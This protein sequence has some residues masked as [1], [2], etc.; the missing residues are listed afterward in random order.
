MA[1]PTYDAPSENPQDQPPVQPDSTEI[2]DADERLLNAINSLE[3]VA[4]G[5]AGNSQ[6][7]ADRATAIREYFGEPYGDEKPGRSSVVARDF[8]ETVE[9]IKPSLIRI[10]TAGEEVARFDPVSAEDAPGAEQESLYINHVLTAR[11]SW[12]NIV[13]DWF[14]DALAVRNAYCLAYYDRSTQPEQERWTNQSEIELQILLQDPDVVPISVEGQPDPNWMPPPPEAL[15]D[16]QTGMQMP[17]PPRPQIYEVLINRLKRNNQVRVCVLPPE[18]CKVAED[19]PG[20]SVRC[21]SYFEYWE[22]VPISNLRAMGMDI[23]DDI[24]DEGEEDTEEDEAR[25]R[26]DEDT[27]RNVSAAQDPSMRKVKMRMVWV[28][29]DY[30]GDGLAE[31]RHV[32]IVGNQIRYNE[33]CSQVHVASIVPYPQPHRHPGMSVWDLL[34]D[35]QKI[36][37]ALWRGALDNIYLANNGRTGI[38]DKVNMADMLTSRPG[39]VVR[40]KEGLPGEHIFPFQHQ[41][42]AA[43]V[44]TVMDYV[45]KM[46]NSRT[47]TSEAF[48]GVDPDVLNKSP[49]VAIQKLNLQAQQ[50]IELIARIFAEGVK[51]LC[52]IVH[53]LCVRYGHQQEMVKLRNNW[54]PI[55]PSTFKR[56]YDMTLSVGLGTGAKD[57]LMANLMLVAQQQKEGLAIGLTKPKHLYNTAQEL[58]K[59][60]GFHAPERFFQDPGDADLPQKPSPE[61]IYAQTEIGKAK[62]R[63]DGE[64]TRTAAELAHKEK[65]EAWKIVSEANKTKLTAHH[66]TVIESIKL[67]ATGHNQAADRAMKTE[68][69]QMR[70]EAAA[71]PPV[72]V[73]MGKASDQMMQMAQA[74]AEHMTQATQ[75]ITEAMAKMAEAQGM[76]EVIVRDKNGRAR[77]KKRMPAGTLN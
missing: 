77:G 61:E 38:S 75:V 60:A 12:F 27:N 55:Q 11:N 3:S 67:A 24:P 2:L 7:N 43:N 1:D 19:T 48:T 40:V 37:T 54:V 44:T 53:E 15:I 25:D 47:G 8:F 16:P 66:D 34:S 4:Y 70:A 23:E 9:W 71:K 45:D 22:M 73:D 17:P 51:E 31:Y 63:D 56:R 57:I 32:I 36:K 20:M 52:L 42:I 41:F 58:I 65:M 30:D 72:H 13:H 68:H 35:L 59:A 14:T 28:R 26:Y 64:T 18:R 46:R 29:F 10:F 50:K 69:E 49:G 74:F 5:S 33:P 39:G 62:I 21:A 6:I 76:E